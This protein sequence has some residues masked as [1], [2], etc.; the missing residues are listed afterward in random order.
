MMKTEDIDRK[1]GMPDVDAEWAAFEHKVIDASML[2]RKWRIVGMSRAAIV[3]AVV[4]C[5]SLVAVA[6]ALLFTSVKFLQTAPT[7]TEMVA[8]GTAQSRHPDFSMIQT[9]TLSVDSTAFRFDNVELRTIVSTLAG[10]YGVGTKC[11]NEEASHVRLYILI[12]RK[13]S[14]EEVAAYLSQFEKVWVVFEDGKLIIR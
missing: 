3:V 7:P 8:G 14:V 13:K 1:I 4:G 2:R 9:D 6:S 10:Y 11:E 5:A 12:D